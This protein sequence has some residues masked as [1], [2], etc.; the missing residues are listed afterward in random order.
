MGCSASTPSVGPHD[1]GH[2][3]VPPG[4]PTPRLAAIATSDLVLDFGRLMKSEDGRQELLKYAMKEHSEENILFYDKA[5]QFRK[6]H[7][8]C[9]S[10]NV[11]EQT[12]AMQRDAVALV[13][14][15]LREDGEFA[16][17]L[18]YSNPFKKGMPKDMAPAANMFDPVC[19][20]VHK[21]IEQDIFP[22]F[23]R[24]SY[25]KEL[26]A[27]IPALAKRLTGSNTNQSTERASN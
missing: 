19:R 11:S 26:L 13:N 24:S 20:V 22:R 1:S 27:R 6:S 17:T 2:V 8:S 4:Q 14:Q 5:Q 25:S 23:K 21:T 10:K 12:E 15:F 7:L 18:A 16:L 9:D 3:N